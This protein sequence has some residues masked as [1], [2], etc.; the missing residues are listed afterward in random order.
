ME[1]SLDHFESSET[2]IYTIFLQTKQFCLVIAYSQE[3]T[4]TFFIILNSSN[5]NS[6]LLGP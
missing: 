3:K 4:H 5:L 2:Y 6:R 1:K